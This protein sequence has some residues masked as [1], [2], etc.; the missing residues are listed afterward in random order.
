MIDF[1][2]HSFEVLESTQD[3][4]LDNLEE[5]DE[6][7]C[8]QALKQTKGKGRHGRNWVSPEGNLYLSFL[9]KPRFSKRDFGHVALISGLSIVRSLQ[10]YVQL[11]LKWPNDILLDSKKVC[12]ILI[13]SFDDRLIV[14]IGL[15]LKHAPV[16]VAGTLSDYKLD[17]NQ[18]RDNILVHFSKL[19]KKYHDEGVESIISE[20]MENSFEIGHKMSVKIDEKEIT[21]F[22]QGLDKS[23]YLLLQCD[24][25]N[26]VLTISSGDIFV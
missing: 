16:D 5:L 22:Y 25:T 4:I 26:E 8:V 2:L 18:T 23:G 14:G 9:L 21:G 10:P 12:G 6:G 20:W 1:S 17:I 13:E 19:Y 3:Y 24:K 11:T 7:F 15:N